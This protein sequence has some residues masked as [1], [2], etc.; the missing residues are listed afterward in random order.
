MSAI[1][2]LPA[3]VPNPAATLVPIPIVLLVPLLVVAALVPL[4]AGR[5][6]YGDARA[7]GR[8]NPELW[9]VLVGSL[10]VAAVLPGVAAAVGYLLVR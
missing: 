2:S 9:G 8:D 6:V 7:R 1:P 4:A 3:L 5:L 10:F